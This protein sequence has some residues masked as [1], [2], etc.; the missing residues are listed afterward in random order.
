MRVH[1]FCY[2]GRGMAEDALYGRLIGAGII[3]HRGAGVSAF[4]RRVIATCRI[5]DVVKPRPET[6]I[7]QGSAIIYRDERFTWLIH[8]Q[9]KVGQRLAADWYGS[10]SASLG[11]AVP[12]D[13][14]ALL[15]LDV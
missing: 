11:L 13:V 8:P 5:H 3:E 2:A 10:V 7:G 14:V 9:L 6:M 1:T 4:V 15:E 12:D